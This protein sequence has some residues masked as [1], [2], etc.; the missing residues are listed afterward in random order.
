M[1][2]N[3]TFNQGDIIS[4]KCI[5]GE[6]IIARYQGETLTEYQLSKPATLSPTPNGSIGLVPSLYSMDLTIANVNLLKTAVAMTAPT[7]KEVADQYIKGTSGI[8]PASSLDGLTN[9]K[10]G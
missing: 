6:E 1:L 7:R 3:K 10:N 4:F 5:S 9:A 8:T 2:L